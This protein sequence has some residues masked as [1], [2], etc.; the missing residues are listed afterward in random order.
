MDY[1]LVVLCLYELATQSPFTSGALR[2]LEDEIVR[3]KTIDASERKV[4]LAAIQ[5]MKHDQS[6]AS[7][8]KLWDALAAHRPFAEVLATFR[9]AQSAEDR[10]GRERPT[11]KPR[12]AS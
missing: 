4:I 10:A 9:A 5:D 3:S 6:R 1:K 12:K 2:V 7:T 8:K 11:R